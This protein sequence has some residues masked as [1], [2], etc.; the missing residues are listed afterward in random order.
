MLNFLRV[1][2]SALALS[3][4]VVAPVATVVSADYAYAKNG[5]GGGNG[6]GNGNGGGKGGG[7]GNGGGN[8]KSDDSGTERSVKGNKTQSAKTSKSAKPNKGKGVGR[9]IKNDFKS[10]SNNLKKNGLGGLFKSQKTQRSV[11]R[12]TNKKTTNGPVKQSKRSPV[13]NASFK[14]DPLHPSNLGKLN[15]AINSSP[16]AK[17]AHIANGQYASGKGPVSL[18]AAPAV[19]ATAEACA[20]SSKLP[21]LKLSRVRLSLKK[22]ISL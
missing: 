4:F 12:S 17:A 2:V 22:I 5:N 15:G 8:G 20:P 10:L 18:A 13:R 9:T 19:A 14:S 11:T 3:A 7:N 1:S 6:G 16:N 21:A